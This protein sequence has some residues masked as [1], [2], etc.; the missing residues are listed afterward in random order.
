MKPIVILRYSPDRGQQEQIVASEE[1]MSPQEEALGLELVD[2]LLAAG[3]LGT[4]DLAR[5]HLL[6]LLAQ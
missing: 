4:N 5:P 3:R 1:G 2:P 6:V